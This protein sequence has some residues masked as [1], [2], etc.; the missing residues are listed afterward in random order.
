[1]LVVEQSGSHVILKAVGLEV[2]RHE[3]WQVPCAIATKINCEKS[4]ATQAMGKT[5]IDTLVVFAML[6][7]LVA[8]WR[9]MHWIM[10]LVVTEYGIVAALV[11]LCIIYVM[12]LIFDHY[13]L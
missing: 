13:E 1:L 12:S 10:Q 3:R 6:A 9:L 2:H 7:T 5:F 11:V 8:V 4:T